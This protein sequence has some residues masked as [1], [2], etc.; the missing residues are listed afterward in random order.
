MSAKPSIDERYFVPD[1]LWPTETP[2]KTKHGLG[3]MATVTSVD[4]GRSCSGP[5]SVSFRCDHE[6]HEA[7]M[8]TSAFMQHC[9]KVDS[10]QARVAMNAGTKKRATTDGD[11]QRVDLYTEACGAS[12][13]PM[14]AR[15]SVYW[16]GDDCR[17]EGKVTDRRIELM[18]GDRVRVEHY[19]EYADSSHWHDLN[20]IRYVILGEN[21]NPDK[22]ISVR[23]G[24]SMRKLRFVEW[25][26][27]SGRLA[28]ALMNTGWEGILHDNNASAI[29]WAKHGYNPS[30][31]NFRQ[32]DFLAVDRRE[33]LNGI[34]FDFFHFSIEC[35]S[36]SGLARGV[37]RR[38][39]HN[40]YTGETQAAQQGNQML[41]RALDMINDQL[42]MNPACLYT[43]EN[44]VGDMQKHPLIV[45]R[46]EMAR[47]DGG[48]GAVRCQINYCFFADNPDDLV[49]HKP[50]NFWTNSA[51]LIQL[52]G[53]S[54]QLPGVPPPRFVCSSASPCGKK[55]TPVA[56]NTAAATPFPPKLAT[57]I[58]TMINV[59]ASPQRFT[60]F[61]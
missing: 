58:A 11:T 28:F 61:S 48:L 19:V 27:G 35:S 30:P 33:L 51:S 5:S 52:F 4:E 23:V 10:S 39:Q 41:A 50:T 25:F 7:E 9:S 37:N 60:A 59:E 8:L 53:S 47:K 54:Q 42:E 20:E 13:P 32:D 34:P 3:W 55:H 18:E 40:N 26:A 49:F 12:E 31:N 15:L 14:H 21:G 1:W 22:E 57:M 17:Y 56:G 29:E 2:R 45:S 36:F 24:K 38:M 44:P 6:E 16:P 43:L 46:L